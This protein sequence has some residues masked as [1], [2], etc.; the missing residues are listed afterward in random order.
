MSVPRVMWNVTTA[1][2]IANL[3]SIAASITPASAGSLYL[4]QGSDQGPK[5][6]NVFELR[7]EHSKWSASDKH[8]T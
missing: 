5:R 8:T 3:L 2:V 4:F 1:I 6:N 7:T